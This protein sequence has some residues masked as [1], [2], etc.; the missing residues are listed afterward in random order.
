M[1][2]Y[3]VWGV[4]A[5]FIISMTLVLA[6]KPDLT[7]KGHNKVVIPADAVEVSPNV[8]S[9]GTK[10]DKDG[11]VVEGF[12]FID[13]KKEFSHKGESATTT[14]SCYSFIANNAKWKKIENW[15][16]NAGNTEGLDG[17]F[18]LNNLDS[19]IN[20]WENSAGKN[21]FVT[22]SLTNDVLAI[23]TSSPDNKN[24]VYFGDIS[25]QGAIAVTIVWGR[26]YGPLSQRELVEWDQIYDQVDF[27]WSS[28][29]EANKMDFENINTHELGHSFGMG[30]PSDGCT[31]E[32]MFRFADYGE[33]KKRDLNFGDVAGIRKLY[34]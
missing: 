8:F 11:K 32:T 19:S 29:G 16:V 3:I 10:K 17:N 5:I 34:K 26:F 12:A 1:K 2:K 6:D 28:S 33:T 24:E 27:D 25:Y 18:I 21:S 31:E 20:K 14:S 30:H 7:V 15:I 22:G 9:L 23:D 13:Y 4:L